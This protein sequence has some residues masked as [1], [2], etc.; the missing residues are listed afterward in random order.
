MERALKTIYAELEECLS[1]TICHGVLQEARDLPCGHTFC[2]SCLQEYSGMKG[3]TGMVECCL[4][5]RKCRVPPGGLT[6]LPQNFRLKSVVERMKRWQELAESAIKDDDTTDV[7]SG[8]VDRVAAESVSSRSL[9]V[10]TKLAGV[11]SKGTHR[12][13]PNER[14]A[15]DHA[16]NNNSAVATA[17]E[18]DI[19]GGMRNTVQ[20]FVRDLINLESRTYLILIR[21]KDSVETM[22]LKLKDKRSWLPSTSRLVFCGKRLKGSMKLWEYGIQPN[23]TIDLY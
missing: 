15:P 8:S 10:R 12:H 18:V 14:I 9:S 5:Q 1:C 21:L 7:H 4:C 13:R 2:L 17:D 22:M 19:G 23:S 11:S 3:W 16:A 6:T 20:I